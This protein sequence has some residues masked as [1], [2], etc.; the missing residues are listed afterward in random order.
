M[1][2]QPD[3]DTTV[4]GDQNPNLQDQLNDREHSSVDRALRKIATSA[5][6][7]ESR[8]NKIRGRGDDGAIWIF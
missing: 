3:L 5:N 6:L 4:A 8:D 7:C 1:H 2:K